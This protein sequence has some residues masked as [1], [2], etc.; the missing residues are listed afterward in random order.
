[1]RNKSYK[2]LIVWQQAMDLAE[3]IY[4]ETN[5][6]PKSEEFSLK[7]QIRRSAVSVPSNIA[8]ASGRGTDKDQI[9][10]LRIALGSLRELDTQIEIAHRVGYMT[11]TVGIELGKSIRSVENLLALFIRSLET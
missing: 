7:S 1:M 4:R 5:G 6:L 11:E 8:E 2:D 10:F 9:Q 3:S